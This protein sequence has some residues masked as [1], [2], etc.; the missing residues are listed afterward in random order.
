MLRRTGYWCFPGREHRSIKRLKGNSAGRIHSQNTVVHP[1][2]VTVIAVDR[3]PTATAQGPVSVSWKRDGDTLSL[4][5]VAPES[6]QVAFV[7]NETLEGLA[8]I[9]NGKPWE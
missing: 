1:V 5:Y 9:V 3:L 8:L 6:V 7:R 4:D 2:S